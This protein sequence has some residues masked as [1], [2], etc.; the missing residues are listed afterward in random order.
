MT[1]KEPA[2]DGSMSG[3]RL[4]ILSNMLAP[5]EIDNDLADEVKEECE[6]RCGKVLSVRVKQ[7]DEWHTDVRVFVL[8]QSSEQAKHAASLFNGRNFGGRKVSAFKA[9]E[10]L[11]E[12]T[13][14]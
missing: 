6:E 3:S 14:I 9:D 13:P 5:G 10:R 8:F 7:A 12:N 4:V 1:S 11:N 2:T